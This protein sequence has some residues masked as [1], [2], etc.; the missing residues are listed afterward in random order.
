MTGNA[1]DP[2]RIDN[3]MAF[4]ARDNDKVKENTKTKSTYVR[5]NNTKSLIDSIYI[6][7]QVF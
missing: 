6:L 5:L 4:S 2:L 7:Y 1:G 3:G